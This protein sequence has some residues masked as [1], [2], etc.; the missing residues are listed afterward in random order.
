MRVTIAWVLHYCSTSP[1]PWGGGA[2]S[3]TLL[4]M[5]RCYTNNKRIVGRAPWESQ[6]QRR[7]CEIRR[8]ILTCEWSDE[9]FPCS[10]SWTSH[11]SCTRWI[12]LVRDI[13]NS[14]KSYFFLLNLYLLYSHFMIH[15]NRLSI[16][17]FIQ[18]ELD[19]LKTPKSR[20]FSKN[21]QSSCYN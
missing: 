11:G 7:Q 6:V 15:C 4:A 21:K 14:N 10:A 20:K 18:K 5:S 13:I 19:F 2:I 1:Q 12:I 17:H 9:T 3:V 16:V 8:D